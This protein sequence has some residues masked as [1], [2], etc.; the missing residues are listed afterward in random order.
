MEELAD[1]HI[2]K[3]SLSSEKRIAWVLTWIN[4]PMPQVSIV[5]DKLKSVPSEFLVK[6]LRTLQ[7]LKPAA[8]GFLA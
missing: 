8:S 2:P 4:I 5:K 6:L 7:K 3:N 1:A